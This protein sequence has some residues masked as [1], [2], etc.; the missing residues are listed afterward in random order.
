MSKINNVIPGVSFNKIETHADGRGFFREILRRG[1]DDSTA[2]GQVSHSLVYA[3]IVKAWHGH[4]IQKQWNY[5]LSG[6]LKVALLD[7]REE[8][9]T[10][11]RTM[12][13]LAGDYQDAQIYSFPPGVLHGYRCIAGPMHI[14]YITSGAYDVHEELKIPYNAPD[15]QYDWHKDLEIR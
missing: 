7:M 3:G 15:V 5:I 1:D 2:I 9:T 11:R 13:F 4:K 10:Y 8:S 12:E 14:I 6:L